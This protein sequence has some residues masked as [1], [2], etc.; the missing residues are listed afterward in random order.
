M[1]PYINPSQSHNTTSFSL[2]LPTSSLASPRSTPNSSFITS[3]I[4][5]PRSSSSYLSPRGAGPGG[6]GC[7]PVNG[8]GGDIHVCGSPGLE[9]LMNPYMHA[10]LM[11]INACHVPKFLFSF[12]TAPYLITRQ[13][14][15]YPQLQ[16]HH[17]PH[18]QSTQL[19]ILPE[20]PGRRRSRRRG[21]TCRSRGWLWQSWTG[22]RQDVHVWLFVLVGWGDG[23]ALCIAGKGE[24]WL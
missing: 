16:L 15:Q 11:W 9:P 2:K 8:P 24:K 6:G 23:W 22:A 3:P 13:S 18:R 21:N 5:S 4:A 7:T 10:I 12:P 1:R 20:P 17:Q 19:L 14:P